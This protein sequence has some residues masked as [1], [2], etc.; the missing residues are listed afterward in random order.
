MVSNGT[1]TTWCEAG[2]RFDNTIMN[3]SLITTALLLIANKKKTFVFIECYVNTLNTL[4]IFT[5]YFFL[6]A[7]IQEYAYLNK[8]KNQN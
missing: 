3:H 1:S 2:I 4:K 8:I 7:L 5:L 6:L